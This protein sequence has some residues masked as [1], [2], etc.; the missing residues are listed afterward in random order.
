MATTVVAV[1]RAVV[2]R[3]STGGGARADNWVGRGADG[4]TANGGRAQVG[5]K[6]DE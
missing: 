1:A 3:G 2:S 5:D 6:R 4:S